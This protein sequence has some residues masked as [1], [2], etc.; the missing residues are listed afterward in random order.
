MERNNNEPIPPQDT[1]LTPA[2]HDGMIAS[3]EVTGESS[4]QFS[5]DTIMQAIWDTFTEQTDNG[6]TWNQTL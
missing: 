2:E 4:L 1:P 5:I 3:D 6:L